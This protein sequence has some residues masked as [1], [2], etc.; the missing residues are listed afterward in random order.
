MAI[1]DLIQSFTSKQT[2]NFATFL[3]SYSEIRQMKNI[4][5]NLILMAQC[6]LNEYNQGLNKCLNH[7]LS[8]DIDKLI[9]QLSK[10]SELDQFYCLIFPVF[11]EEYF[12]SD[13]FKIVWKYGNFYRLAR[14]Y[15]EKCVVF[16][17][18]NPEFSIWIVNN[19]VEMND[20][21][22]ILCEYFEYLSHFRDLGLDL[23]LTDRINYLIE[24]K[25]ELGINLLDFLVYYADKT[26]LEILENIKINFKQ[27][28]IDSKINDIPQENINK[29]IDNNIYSSSS[30]LSSSISISSYLTLIF[31]KIKSIIIRQKVVKELFSNKYIT[32]IELNNILLEFIKIDYTSVFELLNEYQDPYWEP[33][34]IILELNNSGYFNNNDDSDIK[35]NNNIENDKFIN[36]AYSTDIST[37]ID[38][39]V[40]TFDG[41]YQSKRNDILSL[42]KNILKDESLVN[43][44]NKFKFCRLKQ[45]KKSELLPIALEKINDL[46]IYVLLLFFNESIVFN[47]FEKII[48]N[49]KENDDFIKLICLKISDN[50][51]YLNK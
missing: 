26:S 33:Y 19:F 35:I 29:S 44:V 48:R 8:N 47:N 12:K 21:V 24:N 15:S 7:Y 20:S 28:I 3:S 25:D 32:R 10:Y 41:G 42:L 13:F 45:L 27:N 16:R 36:N 22:V 51:R 40:I 4:S 38:P 49:F 11:N 5:S 14:L 6:I 1:L 17:I 37:M 50:D 39:M 23:I 46:R 9:L 18:F 34:K 43:I 31:K 2:Q 30:E